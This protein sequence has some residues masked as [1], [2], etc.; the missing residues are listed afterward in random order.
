MQDAV[1]KL[2][3]GRAPTHGDFN[4]SSI[5]RRKVT[6]ALRTG[7]W[8]TLNPAQQRAIDMIVEKL[9][10]IVHGNHDEKDHWDDI[11][12]YARLGRHSIDYYGQQKLEPMEAAEVGMGG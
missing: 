2:I 8:Y 12:G 7:L 10:R 1:D 6:E 5:T 3:N 4:V 11:A 9:V